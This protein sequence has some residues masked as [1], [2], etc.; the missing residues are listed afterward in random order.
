[1]ANYLKYSSLSEGSSSETSVYLI[2]QLV[3]PR[4]V[5]DRHTWPSK[6]ALKF[7]VTIYRIGEIPSTDLRVKVSIEVQ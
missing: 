1:M 2:E 6:E 3:Q 5:V 4:S 7:E